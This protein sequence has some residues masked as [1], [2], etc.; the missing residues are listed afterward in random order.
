[1][2]PKIEVLSQISG[3]G[4]IIDLSAD[5]K[6]R[7]WAATSSGL[8]RQDEDSCYPFKGNLP[9]PQVSTLLQ[10]RKRL[11]IGGAAG[12]IAYSLDAG[13]SWHRSWLDQVDSPVACMIPSPS[14]SKDYILLAGTQGQGIL[15]STDG[16]RHW[17]LENFGLQGFYVFGLA[18]VAVE[19]TFRELDYTRDY[20]YA[21]TDDGIYFSPNGGRAWKPAGKETT[22]K[23]FLS[24]AVSIN[25]DADQTVYAG[26]E[27]GEVYRSRDGGA[28]WQKLDIGQRS[29][30]AINSIL[31][32]ENGEIL[33]GTSEAGILASKDGGDH[34]SPRLP[35]EPLVIT[36]KQIGDSI[37]AGLYQVGLMTS[38]DGG[39]SWNKQE[40][41]SSRHFEWFQRPGPDTFLCAGLEEGLWQFINGEWTQLSTWNETNGILGIHADDNLILVV[42]PDGIWRSDDSGSTWK[43]A[44]EVATLEPNQNSFQDRFRFTSTEDIIWCGGENGRIY[45]SSDLGESWGPL[46]I[47][48][49]GSPVMAITALRAE[50]RSTLIAGVLELETG[51]ISIYYT[52]DETRWNKWLSRESGWYSINIATI[53]QE[54]YKK[55]VL[56][57]GTSV[58]AGNLNDDPE[59]LRDLD[60]E[61]ITALAKNPFGNEIVVATLDRFH[62]RDIDGEWESFG[63]TKLRELVVD[64]IFSPQFPQDQSLFALTSTGKLLRIR[65]GSSPELG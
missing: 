33:T 65:L 19:S 30:G 27:T 64:I 46:N 13:D 36:L 8:F 58:L 2:N 34:W 3:G 50:T 10:V 20:V 14:Y 60:D 62:Y 38:S 5:S 51:S 41:F 28:S 42:A 39:H 40:A 1:M 7:L 35:D 49:E 43:K 25:F 21:A 18:A 44:V 4:T 47:P 31:C 6:G 61:L 45:R 24:V 37:Y 16:G 57:L 55:T 12:G 32:L 11:F 59:I 22:A 26:S 17:Q 9:F 23:V 53:E 54:D 29:L 63:E 48:F 15:R 52:E 56:G